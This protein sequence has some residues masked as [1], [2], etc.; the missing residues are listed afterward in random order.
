MV[1]LDTGVLFGAADRDDPR[2]GDCRAVLEGHVG[3]LV[4]PVPVIIE[5]AWLIEDRLGPGAEA[6][7]LRG[8]NAGEVERVD[9]TDTDWVRVLELVETYADLGLGTVDAAVIAVAERLGIT[10]VATLNRRDFA[11]VRPVHCEAL[12]LIP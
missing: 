6:T 4:A 5:T 8:V 1:V 11:V 7:F 10:T 9:L 2:H 3:E 12:D